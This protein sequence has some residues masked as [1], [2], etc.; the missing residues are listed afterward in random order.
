MLDQSEG[1]LMNS[2]SRL[3]VLPL[4]VLAGLSAAC[5]AGNTQREP[6]DRATVTSEDL[7]NANEPIE[8]TLQKKVPGLVVT[9]T[10]EGEIA[11]EIRGGGSIRGEE[12]PPLWILDGQPFYPGPGGV[13]AGVSPESIESIRVL[14][15]S[16]AG[17]Y[18]SQGGNG[19]IVITTKRATRKTK[20]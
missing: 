2:A 6:S 20:S 10:A 7:R 1:N 12:S 9:R 16:E 3:L 8:V 11:L 14:R 5:A 15:S 18:G 17:L 19:V 4:A 13:L